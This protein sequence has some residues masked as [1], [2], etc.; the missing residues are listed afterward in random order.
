MEVTMLY[1]LLLILLFLLSLTGE[2]VNEVTSFLDGSFI[3]GTHDLRELQLGKYGLL[4][5]SECLS[6]PFPPISKYKNNHYYKHSTPY[7]CFKTGDSRDSSNVNLIVLH[8]IFLRE[9]NRI[10]WKLHLLNPHWNNDQLFYTTRDI[11]GAILQHITYNEYLPVILGYKTMKSLKLTSGCKYHYN[12]KLNPSIINSVATAVFRFSHFML[13]ANI[14]SYYDNKGAPVCHLKDNF[15]LFKKHPLICS[16]KKYYFRFSSLI[17]STKP[18]LKTITR[19]PNFLRGQLNQHAQKVSAFRIDG[20][21]DIFSKNQFDLGSVFIQKGRDH[22]LPGYT[23]YRKLCAS[24]YDKYVPVKSFS[25]LVN[26]PLF[27]RKK[28]KTLYKCV[29]DIDLLVGGITETPTNGAVFGPLF[30]CLMGTQMFKLKFGDR[31][32]YQ[33]HRFTPAQLASISSVK[34]SRI[35]YDNTN[36]RDIQPNPFYVP[37]CYG[38]ECGYNRKYFPFKPIDLTP[39]KEYY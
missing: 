20:L 23:H 27:V 39:W 9:H 31:F 21:G 1:Y 13:R 16:K 22:G 14:L 2:Q 32:W 30:Q 24:F 25:D 7:P 38:Y 18:L 28:L 33:N 37:H 17:K 4:R 15:V 26:H 11:I 8:T 12:D 3:Y 36:V 5:T 10:A 19:F 35:I 34:M 6:L 29:D